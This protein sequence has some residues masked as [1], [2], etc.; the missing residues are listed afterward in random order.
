MY[1]STGV[2]AFYIGRNFEDPRLERGGDLRPAFSRILLHHPRFPPFSPPTVR[3]PF[4][5]LGGGGGG[6]LPPSPPGFEQGGGA[7]LPLLALPP[8]PLPRTQILIMDF[9][10]PK[11][12]ALRAGNEKT[13]M[14]SFNTFR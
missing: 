7:Q 14:I 11:F 2:G 9:Y 12:S 6:G 1:M 3:D 8:I 13:C 5:P 10:P 4:E